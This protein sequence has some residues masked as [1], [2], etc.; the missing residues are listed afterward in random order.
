MIRVSVDV[1]VMVIH[2]S[3]VLVRGKP[4]RR[5]DKHG[6]LCLDPSAFSKIGLKHVFHPICVGI[7]IIT[8]T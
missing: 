4:L 3:L 7:P 6:R 1:R 5:A 8:H 2:S